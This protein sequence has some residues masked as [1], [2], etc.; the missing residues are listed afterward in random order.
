MTKIRS[1]YIEAQH[2]VGG[3]AKTGAYGHGFWQ[4]ILEVDSGGAVAVMTVP[5]Q[6]SW[7]PYVKQGLSLWFV[8]STPLLP[9]EAREF[10][11]RHV[12]DID[13]LLAGWSVEIDGDIQR[14]YI[15]PEARQ[16][17]LRIQDAWSELKTAFTF[18]DDHQ[19]DAWFSETSV[20]ELECYV[21]GR[22]FS[23]D[24]QRD[25]IESELESLAQDQKTVIT[26]AGR[27]DAAERLLKDAQER[28]K[29]EA[30]AE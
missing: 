9:E 3:L 20:E 30:E 29:A 1:V 26:I 5:E 28:T 27:R 8:R 25:L 12:E 22:L 7:P 23:E 18:L 2:D 15:T 11:D 21:S 14:V 16:A 19:S 6:S 10:I 13:E 17:F 24:G 4:V